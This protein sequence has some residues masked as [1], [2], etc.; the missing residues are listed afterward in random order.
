[1]VPEL[2]HRGTIC[3]QPAALLLEIADKLCFKDSGP[4]VNKNKKYLKLRF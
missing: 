4:K 1:M 2:Q 3:L